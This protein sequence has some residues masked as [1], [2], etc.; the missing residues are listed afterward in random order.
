MD[1]K[2][3]MNDEYLKG[4]KV[5]E[6]HLDT[7]DLGTKTLYKGK[8]KR[9]DVKKYYDLK[10]HTIDEGTDITKYDQEVDF[11]IKAHKV[12]THWEYCPDTEEEY[13]EVYVNGER[14]DKHFEVVEYNVLKTKLVLTGCTGVG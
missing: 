3:T 2:V 10:D 7:E 6:V 12:K 14:F 4:I 8:T 5:I 13:W 1:Y 11:E 9:I